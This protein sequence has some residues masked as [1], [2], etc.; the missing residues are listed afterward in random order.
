MAETKLLHTPDTSKV[1]TVVTHLR[2]QNLEL[3]T[4]DG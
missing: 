1:T 3:N 4:A 2:I